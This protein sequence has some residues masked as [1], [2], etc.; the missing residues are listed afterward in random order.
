MGECNGS[1]D[2][3]IG[4]LLTALVGLFDCSVRVYCA[5]IKHYS[6]I[7]QNLCFLRNTLQ[8]SSVLVD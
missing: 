5:I 6:D 8:A 7:I 2:K 1:Y 3:H 4:E